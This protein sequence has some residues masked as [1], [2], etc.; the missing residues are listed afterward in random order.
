MVD[1]ASGVSWLEGAL[2]VCNSKVG[3][4]LR[5]GSLDFDID[6]GRFAFAF[7]GLKG[8]LLVCISRLGTH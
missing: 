7:R 8:A 1:V 5:F 4:A 3:I 2:L 6:K